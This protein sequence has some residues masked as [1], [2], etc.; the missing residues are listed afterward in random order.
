MMQHTRQSK[1][2][3]AIE[4]S[5]LVE[6]YAI[7]VPLSSHRSA[8]TQVTRIVEREGPREV[9]TNLKKCIGELTRHTTSGCISDRPVDLFTDRLQL[10]SCCGRL[11]IGLGKGTIA[12][13]GPLIPPLS[14]TGLNVVY[15]S[16]W[17][18]TGLEAE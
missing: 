17:I 5:V 15:K 11:A 12:R 4:L 2:Y 8:G 14:Y 18:E 13:S 16:F 6:K 3:H 7:L 9:Y 1:A 10:Q